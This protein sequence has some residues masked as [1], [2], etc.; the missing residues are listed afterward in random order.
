[1]DAEWRT[2]LSDR[3]SALMESMDS[4]DNNCKNSLEHYKQS[5]H[6]MSY[7]FKNNRTFL[8]SLAMRQ[9]ELTESNAEI[10]DWAMKI[11]SNNKKIPLP[12]I[13]ISGCRPYT[14]LPQGVTEPSIPYTYLNSIGVS[15]C[16]PYKE[17]KKYKPTNTLGKKELTP[18]EELQG[19]KNEQYFIF[20]TS[21]FSLYSKPIPLNK[22]KKI[23]Q[24]FVLNCVF[25]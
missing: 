11:A 20:P 18:E 7:D 2:V 5:F 23:Q 25:A 9:R 6:M 13:R 14:I 4:R 17:T 22:K 12:Q 16:A 10:L 15:P 19:I 8:E 21:L 1:M 3:D 24:K